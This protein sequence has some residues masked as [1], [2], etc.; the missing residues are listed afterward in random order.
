MRRFICW[1]IMFFWLIVIWLMCV[2]WC[3]WWC[4]SVLMMWFGVSVW[5]RF[6]NGVVC[7]NRL[8]CNG[9]FMCVCWVMRWCGIMFC[10][11]LLGF[12]NKI[13]WLRFCSIRCRLSLVMC[14]GLIC[15]WCNM[16]IL[17]SL[18]VLLFCWKSV[19]VV[20]WFVFLMLLLSVMVL[21]KCWLSFIC[22]WV[23]M[24][25]CW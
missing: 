12:L 20:S 8:C 16:K 6:L 24:M 1:F 11:L 10:V 23:V 9:W 3:N 13:C 17:V 5:L 19:C 15:W 25:L 21:W 7:W 18:N 4:V 22:V 14:S 2:C